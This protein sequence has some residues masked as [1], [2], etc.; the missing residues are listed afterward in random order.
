[1][2]PHEFPSRFGFIANNKESGGAP[3]DRRQGKAQVA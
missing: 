2:M 3:P 1:V